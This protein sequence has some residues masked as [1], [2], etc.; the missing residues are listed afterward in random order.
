[1]ICDYCTGNIDEAGGIYEV[2]HSITKRALCSRCFKHIETMNRDNIL[3]TWGPFD[4]EV[5]KIASRDEDGMTVDLTMEICKAVLGD[6]LEEM[7]A[8]QLSTYLADLREKAEAL[9]AYIDCS[10]NCEQAWH[11]C[12]C[13]MLDNRFLES[14]VRK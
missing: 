1:M 2:P 11:D 5:E 10:G 12:G 14:K 7:T 6:E 9:D 8:L 13:G 4:E 3:F